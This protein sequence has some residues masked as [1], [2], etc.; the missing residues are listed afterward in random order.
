MIFTDATI[1]TYGQQSQFFGNE[2]INYR[3]KKELSVQGLLQNLTNSSGVSG[4]LNGIAA[5]EA[6]A[7]DWSPII[8]NGVNFGSGYFS[9]IKFDEGLDVR[10]KGYTV[11]V[12]IPQTG[13]INN[14]PTNDTYYGVSYNNFQYI[15]SMTESLSLNR[16]FESDDYSHTIDIKVN[17][18]NITGSVNLAKSVAK[19]LFESNNFNGYAGAYYGLS[20]KKS[21]Y[22]ESYDRVNG[23]C[24]FNQSTKFFN[25]VNGNYSVNKKYSYDR[26]TNGI[27][28]VKEQGEI[29]AL[30]QPYLEV[31]DNAYQTESANAYAN[32]SAVFN[33]Y[34]ENDVYPLSNK[35]IVKGTSLSRYERKLTYNHTFSNDL[36]INDGYYWNYTHDSSMTPEGEVSTTEKGSIVGR[37]H[38]IDT[39][40]NNA[41]IAW[42][43]IQTNIDSRSQ[44]AYDHYRTFITLPDPSIFTLLKKSETH[45]K[46]V[47]NIEYHR[48]YSNNQTLVADDPIRQCKMVLSEQFRLPITQSFNIFNYGVIEQ[49]SNN[50]KVSAI[51]A[52]IE[53]KGKRN[54]AVS[55]YLAYAKIKASNL[56]TGIAPDFMT[57]VSYSLAP[58][59]NH[60]NL[61][62]EWGKL[63]QRS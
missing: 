6:Q 56:V 7:N 19:N 50:Y 38:R 43:N 59:N 14:L 37:G 45:Q 33:T 34:K 49:I 26:E 25:T 10:T 58:F 11:D 24:S 51:S 61:N 22:E 4:I 48:E 21:V 47:G 27:V 31:L 42:N 55:D 39:K 29:T 62:I 1:L 8:I 46:H 16:D 18:A 23:E 57:N 12:V 30:A 44:V 54:T 40:Y 9:N 32:C 60:F 20:G 36:A 3:V 63:Y 5:L 53:L 41:V 35:E 52:S 17:T 13:S 15:E 2:V 28:T